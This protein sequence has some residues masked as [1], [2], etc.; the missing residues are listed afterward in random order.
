M[1][2][3]KEKKIKYDEALTFDDVLLVPSKSDVLP[4]QVD[5]STSL[6]KKIKLKIVIPITHHIASIINI[7]STTSGAS[8]VK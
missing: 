6:T 5:T 8:A 3:V 2:L 1:V 4:S 7:C